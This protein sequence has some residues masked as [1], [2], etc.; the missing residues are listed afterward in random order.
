[1]APNGIDLV[2]LSTGS[3][4]PPNVTRDL[5]R[6]SEIGEEAYQVYR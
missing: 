1:M 3:I 5:L 6:A 4:A 2:S